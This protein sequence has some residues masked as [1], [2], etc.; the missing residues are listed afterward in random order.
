MTWIRSHHPT[1]Q[2]G[3]M[4]NHPR[5]VFTGEDYTQC[6]IALK[7]F[8]SAVVIVIQQ[9][10]WDAMEEYRGATNSDENRKI[11]E[12]RRKEEIEKRFKE[13]EEERSALER[14]RLQIEDDKAARRQRWPRY[15]CV[16][17]I[18]YFVNGFYFIF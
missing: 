4:T 17:F 18:Q 1:E 15:V 6:L 11:E 5:K 10:K 12:K 16:L 3:L 8:P 2:F 13:M 14:V 7:L 9:D